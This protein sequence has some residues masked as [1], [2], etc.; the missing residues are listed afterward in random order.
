MKMQIAG[1]NVEVGDALRSHTEE[2]M[3]GL[4]KHFPHVI[5]VDVSFRQERHRN[6]AEVTVSANGITLRAIGEAEDFYL[7]IDDAGNKLD[8]QLEKYKGRLNKHRQRREKAAE[9][10]DRLQSLETT[11]HRLEEDSLDEAPDDLF[12]EY[13]PKIVH[14]DV[15]KVQTL[16]VD[17]AVMQMDLLH[18]NFFIFQNPN[19][20]MLNVVYREPNGTIGW[21]EPKPG[22]QQQAA[23]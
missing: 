15:K 2:R 5:D 1:L 8:R 16:S 21:V 17:E 10:L 6:L 4:K 3:E 7:A 19:T 12:A 13:M 23:S 11:Y 14:K 20:S 22:D 18:T 9:H